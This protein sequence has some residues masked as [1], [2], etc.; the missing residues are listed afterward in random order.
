M[1]IYTKKAL[2]H[3]HFFKKTIFLKSEKNEQHTP[4]IVLDTPGHDRQI[5]FTS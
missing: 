1:N 3:P 4:T 2:D 5:H